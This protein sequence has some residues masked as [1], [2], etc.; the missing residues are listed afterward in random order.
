M[1]AVAL[2]VRSRGADG[3]RCRHANIRQPLR[4]AADVCLTSD[5]VLVDRADD[6]PDE[7]KAPSD[8]SPL[9][10]LERPALLKSRFE[11]DWER[12]L[13]GSPLSQDTSAKDIDA[14]FA[15]F[16]CLKPKQ[17]IITKSLQSL[18]A[19]QTLSKRTSLGTLFRQGIS[20]LE[21]AEKHDSRRSN[22]L[23]VSRQ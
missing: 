8:A 18:T 15:D 13:Q 20:V 5:L 9:K 2:A 22:V 16:F 4:C 10:R 17:E 11:T 6:M 1:D 7:A 14:F 19:S 23:Q 3:T 12:I 21:T